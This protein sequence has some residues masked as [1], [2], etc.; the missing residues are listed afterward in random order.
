M[1]TLS[2]FTFFYLF[3]VAMPAQEL[4]KFFIETELKAKFSVGE[5]TSRTIN[6]KPGFDVGVPKLSKH[7]NPVYGIGF[8]LNYNLNKH[9]ST[10]VGLGINIS[11]FEH[12]PLVADEYYDKVMIPMYLRIRYQNQFCD[13][14]FFLS[15]LNGG[16]QYVDHRFGYSGIGYDYSESGGLLIGF[17]IGIGKDL[18][19]Y[20][21][22][23]KLGYELNQF[24]N[25]ASLGWSDPDFN[26][27]DKVYFNTYYHLIKCSLSLKI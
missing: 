23:F 14:W 22:I 16:Y 19:K 6:I 9:F 10:G 11:K 15:D 20:T 7:R 24:S 1:K 27:D 13:N 2:I 18:G 21:P 17:D 26:Y 4:N 8:N 12:H 5:T 3:R 25:E